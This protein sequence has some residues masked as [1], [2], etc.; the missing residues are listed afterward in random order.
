M[1]TDLY[2]HAVLT[3]STNHK[4]DLLYCGFEN[5]WRFHWHQKHVSHAAISYCIPQYSVRCKFVSLPEIPASGTKIRICARHKEYVIY[6]KNYFTGG[7]KSTWLPW[8]IGVPLNYAYISDWTTTK[9]S[10][11]PICYR[12]VLEYTETSNAGSIFITQI[13]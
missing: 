6:I 8:T 1:T 12:L 5:T 3:L 9:Q 2:F 10:P 11:A 7:R 13:N 4:I